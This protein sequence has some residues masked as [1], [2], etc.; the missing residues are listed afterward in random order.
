MISDP[1]KPGTGILPPCFAGRGTLLKRIMAEAD[2][3]YQAECGAPKRDIVLYGPQG[4]GKTTLL[5]V[6]EAKLR[7]K[8]EPNDVKRKKA[9]DFV[10][11]RWTPE[12]ELQSLRK[13]INAVMPTG[14]WNSFS[15]A[16]DPHN[17]GQVVWL[18]R[19]FGCS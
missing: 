17:A 5:R 14:L 11:M 16:A 4:S 6:V 9:P 8:A 18:R 1:F 3:L 10:V 19:G 12:I 2:P 7:K 13:V 15:E